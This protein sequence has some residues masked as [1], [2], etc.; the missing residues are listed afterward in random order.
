MIFIPT[1]FLSNNTVLWKVI[2]AIGLIQNEV[3]V[4]VMIAVYKWTLIVMNLMNVI[5]INIWM[6]LHLLNNWFVTWYHYYWLIL[7]VLPTDISSEG[8]ISYV[9]APENVISL[10]CLCAADDMQ[11]YMV[12]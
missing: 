4:S 8:I 2:H 7:H 5:T 10:L 1:I 12:M 6:I 11:L 3:D 9:F